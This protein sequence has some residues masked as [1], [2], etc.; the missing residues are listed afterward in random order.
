MGTV[1]RLAVAR[2]ARFRRRA[3]GG[4]ALVDHA[5]TPVA[6]TSEEGD[7]IAVIVDLHLCF[8][9]S[10]FSPNSVSLMFSSSRAAIFPGWAD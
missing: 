1:V 6:A 10:S 5:P 8:Q 2:P 9:Q 3:S 4:A 7:D